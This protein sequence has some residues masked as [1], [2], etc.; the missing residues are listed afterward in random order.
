MWNRPQEIAGRI[1]GSITMIPRDKAL[2]KA[3][4]FGGGG[5]P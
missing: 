4:A 2:G 3:V 5:A 1:K